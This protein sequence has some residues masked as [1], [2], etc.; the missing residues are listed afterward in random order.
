V[1]LDE[2]GFLLVPNLKRTWAPRGK[3]PVHY[4]LYR[5]DKVSA[6]T[7]LSLSPKRRRATLSIRLWTRNITGPMVA[8]FLRQ[9]FRHL[10]GPVLVLWDRGTIHRHHEVNRLWGSTP[11]AHREFFPAYAP[12]LNPAEFVWAQSDSA[13]ANGAPDTLKVLHHRLYQTANRLRRS[14]KLLWAC[15]FASDLPWT[16]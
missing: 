10:R 5:Q 8:A 15:L 13:L 2:S 1:F 7:A 11:R 14:Q 3:T 4:H 6:I 16:R 9:L 12:E